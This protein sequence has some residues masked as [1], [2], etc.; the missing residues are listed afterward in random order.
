MRCTISVMLY[1]II[2]IQFKTEAD[3]TKFKEKLIEG[4]IRLPEIIKP[5][6]KVPSA[7]KDDSKED[8]KEDIKESAKA[9]EKGTTKVE[10]KE[11][12][13]QRNQEGTEKQNENA[14]TEKSTPF[15]FF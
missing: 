9:D 4:L 5:L 10:I 3:C 15:C 12:E 13:K 7:K 2:G 1:E 6:P 8:K 14:Q 11:S